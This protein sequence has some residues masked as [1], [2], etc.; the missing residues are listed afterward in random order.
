MKVT[1]TQTFLWLD[2]GGMS[3]KYGLFDQ[4]GR[5]LRELESTSL[6]TSESYIQNKKVD[7]VDKTLKKQ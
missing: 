6:T 3:I 7:I 5:L 1:D 4:T 2:V